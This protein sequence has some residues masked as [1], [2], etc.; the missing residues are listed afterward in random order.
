MHKDRKRKRIQLLN[1]N[2][3]HVFFWNASDQGEK[4]NSWRLSRLVSENIKLLIVWKGLIR[5]HHSTRPHG[6]ASG[7]PL[8]LSPLCSQNA[9]LSSVGGV[10]WLCSP[11]IT[12]RTWRMTTRRLGNLLHHLRSG[13]APSHQGRGG[14]GRLVWRREK[15]MFMCVC[16]CVCMEGEGAV[17]LRWAAFWEERTEWQDGVFHSF[18][19]RWHPEEGGWGGLNVSGEVERVALQFGKGDGRM[20]QVV[21]QHLDLRGEEPRA[22]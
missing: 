1:R 17:Q 20:L 16:V 9:L 11:H 4:K 12:N 3:K 14:G 8:I 18:T 6:M 13:S 19:C 22:F 21:E 15:E 7:P 10:G 5:W 2:I